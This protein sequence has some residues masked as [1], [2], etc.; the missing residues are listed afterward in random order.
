MEEL[1]AQETRVV[2]R[3][4]DGSGGTGWMVRGGVGTWSDVGV[5]VMV[6]ESRSSMIT[7]VVGG[8]PD[9]LC[10]TAGGQCCCRTLSA[11]P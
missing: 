3:A 8:M 10:G 2:L 9:T 4:V 7:V 11:L 6:L 5:G 1:A